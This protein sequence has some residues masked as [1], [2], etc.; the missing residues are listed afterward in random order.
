MKLPSTIVGGIP[1][2]LKQ[3]CRLEVKH[4]PLTWVG[5][6]LRQSYEEL[7]DGDADVK[8]C[9]VSVTRDAERCG[10]TD[11]LHAF[12][13]DREAQSGAALTSGEERLPDLFA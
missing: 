5:F 11:F 10:A 1:A 3:T 8:Q 7:V 9:A 6:R 12:A 13:N 4:H 2:L